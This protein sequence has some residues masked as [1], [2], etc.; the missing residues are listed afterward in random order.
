MRN[1]LYW[2]WLTLK[3]SVNAGTAAALLDRFGKA[4]E[5]YKSKSYSDIQGIGKEALEQLADKSLDAAEKIAER[6]D[7]IGGYILTIEDEDYPMLL[8]NISDPPYVLYVKGR[9]LD[10][11]RRFAVGVVGTRKCT[12]YGIAAAERI[13]GDLAGAGATIV[14]GMARGIDAAAARAAIKSGGET[15]AVLGSGLDVI[16]PREHEELYEK[17]TKHGAV[18]TEFP[19][20][21]QPLR[22]N[23]PRRN[24]II[25]GMSY[26]VLI[27]Q[28]P[29]KSGALITASLA[30]ENGRDVFAVPGSIF[31]SHQEGAN[32]LIRSGAKAVLSADDIISE[33]PYLHIAP[34]KSGAEESAT[35]GPVETLSYEKE[36]PERGSDPIQREFTDD[37]KKKLTEGLDQNE[38]AVVMRL[39]EGGAHIDELSR[40][41]GLSAAETGTAL[42]MLEMRGIVKNTGGNVF[43]LNAGQNM[44]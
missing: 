5:I 15:V 44:R 30:L 29:K 24:R 14:S 35:V 22:S 32:I 25:A 12:D 21:T 36:A 11:K 43:T 31:D 1:D 16:Y 34:A 8:R 20:G 40:E 33:Y 4:E 6:I 9:K 17:I 27:A 7:E 19:P 42:I 3:S 28:A 26:G 10:W 37:D 41:L 18:M 13:S 39:F 23:F 38:T 2:M